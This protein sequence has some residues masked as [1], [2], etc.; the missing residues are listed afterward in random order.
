MARTSSRFWSCRRAVSQSSMMPPST[1]SNV[2]CVEGGWRA[3]SACSAAPRIRVNGVRKS[4]A[5]LSS[6]SRMAAMSAA[7]LRTT[8]SKKK[9]RAS[10][11]AMRLLMGTVSASQDSLARIL[12]M[13][14]LRCRMGRMVMMNIQSPL[15]SVKTDASAKNVSEVRMRRLSTLARVRCGCLEHALSGWRVDFSCRWRL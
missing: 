13:S 6:V 10:S 11:S 14:A 15:V 4:C 7:F 8:R 1:L 9:P 2:Y 12:D 3:R 5:T